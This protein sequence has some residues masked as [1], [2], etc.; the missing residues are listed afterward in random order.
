MMLKNREEKKINKNLSFGKKDSAI[1]KQDRLKL[2]ENIL[3]ERYL[4]HKCR[5]LIIC[6]PCKR[7]IPDDITAIRSYL[8][9]LRN[10]SDLNIRCRAYNSKYII[11]LTGFG[12]TPL[13]IRQLF[14]NRFTIS[15]LY[16]SR[17][18]LKCFPDKSFEYSPEL[19]NIKSL[20]ALPIPSNRNELNTIAFCRYND[21]LFS[22]YDI[23]KTDF[24]K[25]WGMNFEIIKTGRML[26]K[27]FTSVVTEMYSIL[28][29][30]AGKY[31]RNIAEVKSRL[32]YMPCGLL[33]ETVD[34]RDRQAIPEIKQDVL[35]KVQTDGYISH[36]DFI[37]MFSHI[38]ILKSRQSVVSKYAKEW[39]FISF[40][41]F[42]VD[43]YDNKAWRLK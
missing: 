3:P 33:L 40:K 14:F 36:N 9:K 8:S 23:S 32:G 12:L 42:D 2:S 39:N 7:V 30:Y 35:S 28:S 34:K 37:S 29:K 19:F 25:S 24:V 22:V 11:T 16:V 38:S 31:A 18:E 10:K 1:K 41:L 20:P 43:E 6:K 15:K 5:Y 4:L 21:Y 26:E 27:D 17:L 13:Y